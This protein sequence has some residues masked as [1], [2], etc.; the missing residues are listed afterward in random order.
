MV[1]ARTPQR[2]EVLSALADLLDYPQNSLGRSVRDTRALVAD[3]SPA[4]AALLD[5]FAADVDALPPGRLEELYAVAFDL[6]TAS[7]S[8]T[9]PYIGHHL[10]G[11]SYRRSRFMVGLLERYREHG[12]EV[13]DELPDHLLVI[14]RFLASD[15][16]PETAEVIV[17]EALLP[18][19]GRMTSE[20]DEAELEG[21]SG[22]RVYLRLLEAVRLAVRGLWPGVEVASYD[23]DLAERGIAA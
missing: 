22:G 3:D 8:A 9:Y 19:L 10:L 2:T 14:L 12:F 7:A 11:E 23:T 17:G 16:D 15:P 21:A 18:A 20:G 13:G 6:G 4:A 1:T 5:R